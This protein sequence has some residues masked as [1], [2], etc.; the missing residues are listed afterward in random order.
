MTTTPILHSKPA[1]TFILNQSAK[2]KYHNSL[3]KAQLTIT[4][5]AGPPLQ[6]KNTQLK[7][8]YLLCFSVK[9][10]S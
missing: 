4:I 3:K 5:A 8:N 6:I 10:N 7:L 1:N 2:F 9:S